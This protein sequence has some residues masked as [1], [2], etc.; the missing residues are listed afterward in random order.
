MILV[1]F[2][3]NIHR[4]LYTQVKHTNPR[5]VDGK[6]ITQDFQDYWKRLMFEE[7]F[8]ISNEFSQYLDRTGIVLCLDQYDR[9]YW[10][11]EIYPLYKANRSDSREES[12]INYEEFF[13]IQNELI[14][15]LK[16]NSPYKVFSVPGQE[17]DD[18]ILVLQKE[19]QG[20][21]KI[22]IHS[23]DKD[24]I[25]QQRYSK[26]IKQYSA[27]TKKFITP[28][29]KSGTM[30]EWITEH[31]C[32]G[33]TQDNVPRI[34]DNTVFSNEFKEFLESKDFIIDEI[35]YYKLLN[36]SEQLNEIIKEF[37][38]M[39][40]EDYHE[41]LREYIQNEDLD[42]S[43]KE[44]RKP[45][46]SEIFQKLRFGPQALKKKIKEHGSLK[47]YISSCELLTRNFELNYKLV[48]HEGIP[49]N[50]T[51]EC[52][53]KFSEQSTDFNAEE[54]DK[55]LNDNGLKS[56]ITMLPKEFRKELTQDFFES[57]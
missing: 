16:N 32:L 23:P 50:I 47:E 31:I 34:V 44:I 49:D 17:A 18:L 2:S 4:C 11:K 19:F 43:D 9:K 56:L 55:Y 10:R 25:Q 1:D 24:F 14:Q 13:Q 6:L 21:E 42:N 51:K 37:E 30:E 15:L 53:I 46:K 39:A 28:D 36:K 54:F 41:K 57:W 7:L 33:D 38:D 48:M 8:T 35:Q 12:E 40:E 3:S 27:L 20:T 5:E 29:T 22:L 52:L 26:D 45:V